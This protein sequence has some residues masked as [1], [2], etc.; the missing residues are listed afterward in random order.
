MEFS[1][2]Y[3]AKLIL[4]W[5]ETYLLK[6][7]QF[8]GSVIIQSMHAQKDWIGKCGNDNFNCLAASNPGM[9]CPYFEI[10][11]NQPS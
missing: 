6:R 1:N 2:E 10:Q 9:W 5:K 7:E 11:T 8:C 3:G 4:F